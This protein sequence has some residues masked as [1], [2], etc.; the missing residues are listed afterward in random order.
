MENYFN[1][2]NLINL[3]IKYRLHLVIILIAAVV[4][5][6]VFSSPLF[7]T[8]KFK[9]YAIVYPANISPYSEECILGNTP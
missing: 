1:N 7:I 6:V 8:P 4:L 3:L 2:T 9:S 5:G